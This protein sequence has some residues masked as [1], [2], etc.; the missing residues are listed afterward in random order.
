MRSTHKSL[1]LGMF[2][3]T[4]YL[5]AEAAVLTVADLAPGDLVI[6]EYLANPL[7]VSDTEGEYF[8]IYNRRSEAVD[9]SGL[10]IRDD[11]SNQF[12]VGALLVGAGAFAVFSNGDGTGL[13][14]TVDYNYSTGMSL[15]NTSDEIVLVGAGD[16]QL[17]RAVYTDGDAF[18]AGIAHEL[19]MLS[20]G[21]TQATGPAAGTDY[22]AASAALLQGNLG[23]PGTAGGTALPAVPLPGAGW[24]LGSGLAWLGAAR[25][26]LRRGQPRVGDRQ[27]QG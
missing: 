12:S 7:G 8:E 3:C 4:H 20:P 9:L 22:Q 14:I 17:F 10:L 25:R 27:R 23:S 11:G 19:A 15:T 18:G 1:L 16:L 6:T 24:L 26:P 2:A 5:A 21:L 13:G